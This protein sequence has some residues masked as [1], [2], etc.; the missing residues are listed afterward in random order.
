MSDTEDAKQPVEANDEPEI[1]EVVTESVDEDGD[2]IVDDLVAEVDR[3]G[4]V[5]ATD[6]TTLMRTAE[7]DVMI[8][9]TFSVAGEDGALHAVTEDVTLVEA[10]E[11]DN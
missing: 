1:I 7:G 5:I 3:E 10:E 11:Q 4:N 2:V 8:D 6:E 9:E